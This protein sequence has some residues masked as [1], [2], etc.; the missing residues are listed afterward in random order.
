M[1]TIAARLARASVEAT[2]TARHRR[3]AEMPRARRCG[4]E[5]SIEGRN[6]SSRGNTV[7]ADVVK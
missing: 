2:V 1:I 5:F 3:G 6:Q 7:W 4:H